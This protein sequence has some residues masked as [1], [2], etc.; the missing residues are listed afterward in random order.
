MGCI[1]CHN[2][3]SWDLSSG[4]EVEVGV[5]MRR[6]ER[7]RPFL[8]TPGLTIS[9]GEPLAQPGFA[10]ELI[11]AARSE[12]WHVALD[13]SGWGPCAEVERI[14]RAADM[15]IFSIKHAL[16]PERIAPGCSL[17][18]TLMNWRVL[19]ALPLP[20][21][22]RY[23][24]VPGLTDEP[25]ALKALGRIA[26]ELPNLVKLEILP[27]NRLAEEKWIGIGKVNPLS[28]G[29]KTMVTE[30]QLAQAE[31]MIAWRAQ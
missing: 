29:A 22:L 3:D 23:V 15:V 26:R 12:G 4:E 17:L 21:W 19:A 14:A 8:R 18:D 11:E 31:R 10:L 28:E 13:T 2:P 24:L 27:F 25:E 1:F 16:H 7:Y 30:E 20:V 5:L 9:G 6:L